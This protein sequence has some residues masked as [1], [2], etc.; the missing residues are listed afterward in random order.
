MGT[1]EPQQRSVRRRIHETVKLPDCSPETGTKNCLTS[2]ATI[3]GEPS[4]KSSQSEMRNGTEKRVEEQ[5]ADHHKE[6]DEFRNHV[7]GLSNG[8]F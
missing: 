3:F 4:L 1:D 6:W 8:E 2:R 7:A 5:Q